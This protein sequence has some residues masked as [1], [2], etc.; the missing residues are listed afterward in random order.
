VR[1]LS[2]RT[3]KQEQRAERAEQRRGENPPNHE[4]I[5]STAR[6]QSRTD[7][8]WLEHGSYL[9]PCGARLNIVG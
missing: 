1:A 5:L 2:R 8:A 9:T 6:G 4:V 7:D 3:A